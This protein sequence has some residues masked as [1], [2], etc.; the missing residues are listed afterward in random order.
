MWTEKILDDGDNDSQH[1]A[2]LGKKE[3]SNPTYQYWSPKG[4]GP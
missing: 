1:T 4:P 3:T 2:N